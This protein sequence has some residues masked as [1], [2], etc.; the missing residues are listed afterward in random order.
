MQTQVEAERV[1]LRVVNAGCA[2]P[3]AALA[4]GDGEGMV[5]EAMVGDP[6]SGKIVRLAV[7]FAAADCAVAAADLGRR[8]LD[9]GRRLG[10]LP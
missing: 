5:L 3:V 6:Q 9:V 4:R 1:F 7:R 10:V 8:I 2:A